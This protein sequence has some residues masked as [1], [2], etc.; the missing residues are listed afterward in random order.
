MGFRFR[1]SI[2]ILPGVR[3]NVSTGGAS[4]SLGH[5]GAT[6]NVGKRGVR[7]TYDLPGSGAYYTKEKSWGELGKD[8]DKLT[9]RSTAAPAPGKSLPKSAAP[10]RQRRSARPSS[11]AGS[12]AQDPPPGSLRIDPGARLDLNYFQR[13]S[14][15]DDEEA[16]LDGLKQMAGGDMQSALASLAKATQLADGAFM[17]G[18]AAL[19]FGIYT[20]AAVYLTQALSRRAE[21][22]RVL[23]RYG[24]RLWVSIAITPQVTAH[25]GPSAAGSLLALAEAQQRLGQT[26]AALASLRELVALV[27][28]DFYARLSLVELLSEPAVLPEEVAREIAALGEGVEN[29]NEYCCVLLLYQARALRRLGLNEAARAALTKAL[30]KRKDRSPGLLAEIRMERGDLSALLGDARAARTDFEKAYA[31]DPDCPGL[32]QRLAQ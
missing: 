20:D 19:S 28:G 14:V 11:G 6:V 10:A 23:G 4:V 24:V 26:A 18:V 17:A 16:L 8:V 25:I 7:G 5:K 9:G 30:S 31:D 32:A 13:L 22:G 21:L 29:D 15:P 2:K 12:L 1:K 27:P 3:V